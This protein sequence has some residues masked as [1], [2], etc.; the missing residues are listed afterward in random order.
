MAELTEE[1]AEAAETVAEVSRRLGRRDTGMLGAGVLLGSA[2]GGVVAYVTSRKQLELKYRQIADLEIDVMREHF[3]LKQKEMV[4]EPKP[5]LKTMVTELGYT[6]Q[7][8]PITVEPATPQVLAEVVVNNVFLEEQTDVE[9]PEWDYEFERSKR[10]HKLPYVIHRE[11]FMEGFEVGVDS[12]EEFTQSVLTYFEGDDVLCDER[13]AVVDQRDMIVGDE[14]LS[15]FGHGSGDPNVVYVRN[16]V[17]K[18]DVEIVRSDGTYANQVH[19]FVE[20]SDDSARRR[21]RPRFDD[22]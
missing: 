18:H 1:I 5:D 6:P 21:G 3:F 20:H 15:K 8:E 10:D 7:G 9:L 14:N 2:I 16:E 19:G 11:E 17:L 13:D 12:D 4:S 22:E